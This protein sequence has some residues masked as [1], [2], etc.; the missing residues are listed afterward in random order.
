MK[1]RK[2]LASG[3][4]GGA[5][6][7]G[8]LVWNQYR[9]PKL[10][11][12]MTTDTLYL[13]QDV[14]TDQSSRDSDF[15]GWKEQYHTILDDKETAARELVDVEPITGFIEETDFEESYVLVIQNGMQSRPDLVLESIRREVNGLHVKISINSPRSVPDDLRVHS[16][17]IRITDEKSGIPERVTVDINGYP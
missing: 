6:V 3:G 9:S 7:G 2:Y 17:L 1:R 10:P 15:L 12:G 11:R 8:Y 4:L 13:E 14:L 5:L 16:L